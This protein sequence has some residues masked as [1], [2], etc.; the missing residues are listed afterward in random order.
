MTQ[1][2]TADFQLLVSREQGRNAVA[3]A[4]RL[5]VGRGRRYS[6]KQLSNGSGVPDWQINTAMIEAGHP[7]NRPLPPESLLSRDVHSLPT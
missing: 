3:K 1:S 6:V 7:D 4:L 5:F 2:A